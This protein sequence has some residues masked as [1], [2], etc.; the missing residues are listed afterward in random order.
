MHMCALEE[1]LHLGLAWGQQIIDVRFCPMH[2]LDS[3]CGASDCLT[4]CAPSSI[5][6]APSAALAV[7]AA[8]PL[9][10]TCIRSAASAHA[11]TLCL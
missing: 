5:V 9:R 2:G 8:A 4:I 3:L 10:A 1:L 7:R 11:C 6:D